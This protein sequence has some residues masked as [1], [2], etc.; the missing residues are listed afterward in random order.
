MHR[1]GLKG[2]D[3]EAF[4]RRA[5]SRYG[6]LVAPPPDH[7]VPLVRRAKSSL[8]DIDPGES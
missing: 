2:I 3:L 7:Y 6:A 8:L 4:R 1:A 5:G